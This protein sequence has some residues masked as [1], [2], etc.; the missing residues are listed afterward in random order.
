MY[1]AKDAMTTDVVTISP[2]AT[3]EEAMRLLINQRISGAPVVDRNGKLVGIIS[4]YQLLEVVYDPELKAQHVSD[5]MTRNVI[6]VD[7]EALL[8]SVANMFVLH[9]IRRLP[10]VQSGRLIGV[11][12]RR[13]LLQYIIESG[14]PIQNF[15]DE[16]RSFTKPEPAATGA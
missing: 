13:D 6:T 9:R 8:A 12:A 11:I 4:E 5:F 2:D 3:I 10:V 1:Q 15:F 7:P 16:L 14:A